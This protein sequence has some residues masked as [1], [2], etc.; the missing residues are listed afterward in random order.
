[1]SIPQKPEFTQPVERPRVLVCW[2][3][4]REEYVLLGELT[5]IGRRA[6]QNEIAVPAEFKTISGS[7]AEIRRTGQGFEI[8]DL[9]SSN[10][11]FVNG[12]RISSATLLQDGDDIRIGN[13][14]VG[15]AIHL[16]PYIGILIPTGARPR[17]APVAAPAA[18]VSAGEKPHLVTRW[19][20]GEQTTFVIDKDVVLL[21]R[22]S[23]ADLVVPQTIRF[24]SNRHA[25]IRRTAN[26]FTI[27]D[28]GSMNG[29]YVNNQRLTPSMAQPLRDGAMIRI[30]DESFG[31]SIGLTFSNPSEMALPF[32]GY[33]SLGSV[34]DLAQAD[35]VLIGRDSAC[36][37]VLDAPNVSRKH[38]VI[39]PY[40]GGH[41]IRD[42]GSSNG[43]Y[44]NGQPIQQAVLNVGDAVQIGTFVLTYDGQ[45]LSRFDSQ[46]L[47]MDVADVYKEVN[48]TKGK[49]RIL[50]DVSLTIMP[51]EFVALIGGSGAGKSTL[52]DAL[53]GFR[54][55]KG[56]ILINGRSLYKEYDNF[57]TQ[58]GY[59]PQYDIL[60]TSLTVER[61]LS[62]AAR[63]RL[64]P[65]VT[66]T[67]RQKRIS[68]VLETVGMNEEKIRKT[69]ISAL[70]GGQRKRVSI[71]AELL[72]EPKLFF[73]DEPT[74]GLDPGLEKKMMYTM[75]RMAD[76]GR[77]IIL[78]T[79]AT[80]N[81][82]QVDHVAF[83]SQGRLVYFGPP[84]EA[85][86]FFEV[87]DFAD[88]Y[89]KIER[90]GKEW[91]DVFHAKKPEHYQRYVVGRQQTRQ[92]LMPGVQ[93]AKKAGSG[94]LD[95]LRQFIVFSQRMVNIIFAEKLALG[96][97]LAIMPIIA[98]LLL[99]V[100]SSDVL[101][102]RSDIVKNVAEAVKTMT[103]G[104]MPALDAQTILFSM[105]LA[106]VLVGLF[107]S[108]N[109]LVLERSVYLRERMVNL[110][111]IPYV[112]SKLFIFGLFALVQCA[113]L[114]GV[115]N[116]K[117][118][119]P[120]GGML[121]P[122][123]MEMY[124]TLFM[125]TMASVAMGLFISSISSSTNMVSYLMLIVLFVQIIFSGSIFDLRNKAVEPISYL[126]ITHW[127]L[128]GLGTTDDVNQLAEYTVA[129]GNK[130]DVDK[131]SI[132]IDTSS[133]APVIDT[134]NIR[135][136]ETNE[137]ECRNTPIE[138]ED[139]QVDYGE[140]FGTVFGIWVLL[141]GFGAAFTVATL[142]SLKR[143]D[144]T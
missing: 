59:V 139:M 21:G 72:A 126:T 63:L 105:S 76:E 124:I 45:T 123:T 53:N 101:V 70:S 22:S 46:G 57:R 35:P 78:I 56:T 5:R 93:Q 86:D 14:G 73:L 15:Q 16:K 132:N 138:R 61:A 103:E 92:A 71:A 142:I 39:Q 109:E 36:G 58:F 129:C 80:S 49:L 33:T 81:I 119:L 134:D 24:V 48:T 26:G 75:R 88:I 98:F 18:D 20:S 54:P 55:A 32:R 122:G 82:V 96:I 68:Q 84:Q 141:G 19:P 135:M 131:D 114:L 104:Y 8:V 94:L 27:T 128:V 40:Q 143:L 137:K 79:H 102:G 136:V 13:E 85:L 42:L 113:L 127:T 11:T 29:T 90:N 125:A 50:D 31:A 89:E 67:E 108:S 120:G 87:D 52:L 74:S 121:L 77:T 91:H 38:A 41:L 140:G 43:T 110:K 12:E 99:L 64:P 118:F 65:D 44:V 25:E 6:N 60:H 2:P 117:V 9:N 30:G 7:H 116:M 133:G 17:P 62:Y 10:G 115:L 144:R 106:A 100:S 97:M 95:A 130:M 28:L 69:R 112:A 111:L 3:D 23:Q 1:M 47:R 83:M 34:S 37:I 107:S 51:R 66:P 4:G